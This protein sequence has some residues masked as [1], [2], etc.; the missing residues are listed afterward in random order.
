MMMNSENK[1]F[2]IHQAIRFVS[3]ASG[4]KRNVNLEQIRAFYET[5]GIITL[6]KT[7]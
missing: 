2:R 7:T 5:D 1:I 6:C 3:D 4:K